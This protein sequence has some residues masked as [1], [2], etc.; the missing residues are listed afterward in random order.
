[1]KANDIKLIVVMVVAIIGSGLCAKKLV[2][3]QKPMNRSNKL[4]HASKMPLGGF[5]KFMA[6]I[7]WMR[8][9]NYA[10]TN[11]LTEQNKV[12]YKY[13]VDKII[14]LDPDFFEIYHWGTLFL[15]QVDVEMAVSIVDKAQQ[16]PRL[17]DRYELPLL[18]GQMLMRPEWNK[19]YAGNE[20]DI[21]KE[22]VRRARL[23]YHN[24]KK[25]PNAISACL[26][27]YIRTGALLM[28]NNLPKNL[29]EL[30]AWKEYCEQHGM[31]N[32]ADSPS[33]GGEMSEYGMMDMDIEKRLLSQIRYV[34]DDYVTSPTAAQKDPK[35][36]K[37]AT[38]IIKSI[39][40][41]FFVGRPFDMASFKP[42]RP[43]SMDHYDGTVSM[44]MTK[45]YVVDL[46]S[47]NAFAIEHAA[48]KL[49]KG[50]AKVT[51]LINGK[52]VKGLTD[53]AIKS[54]RVTVPKLVKIDKKKEQSLFVP[55]M[56]AGD[57]Q[58]R[59]SLLEN[60]GKKGSTI[61]I[62]VTEASGAEGLSYKL[63]V[64]VGDYF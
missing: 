45:T 32:G 48:F 24:A 38:R 56:T 4:E 2:E 12:K 54:T 27:S 52:P 64:F 62:K 3:M 34:A 60:R 35:M 8:F 36:K 28:D 22:T 57:F 39:I 20:K 25:C 19:F 6:D 42:Y 13:Y 23:Y 31:M 63:S 61:E 51:V 53:V 44:P 47:P 30:N 7:V 9:L 17:K 29:N 21:N 10:G 18:A 50:T 59:E 46:E 43:S 58:L 26:N 37:E 40:D 1:M 16:N 11:Q 55:I 5:Q 14:A 15:G 33:G 49:T 41:K